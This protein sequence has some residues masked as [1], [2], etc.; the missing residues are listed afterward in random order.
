MINSLDWNEKNTVLISDTMAKKV[1]IFSLI[2]E[3]Q[4][5]I[6]TEI[7]ELQKEINL[8]GRPDNLIYNPIKK[9]F[10]LTEF[11]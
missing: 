11:G 10:Y 7:L 8:D 5:T 9:E 2:D 6:N 3:N 1:R 4:R